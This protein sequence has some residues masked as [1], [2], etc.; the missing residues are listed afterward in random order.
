MKK[1]LFALTLMLVSCAC[2][3]QDYKTNAE[4]GIPL[5]DDWVLVTD[6]EEFTSFVNRRTIQINRDER[7]T[8]VLLNSRD[9]RKAW[10]LTNHKKSQTIDYEKKK[11]KYK[12]DKYHYS[13]LCD[14]RESTAIFAVIYDGNYGNGKAIASEK[15]FP[16]Y[17]G[18]IPDTIGEAYYEY[19]CS[20]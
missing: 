18:V 10:I 12:S 3:S 1:L 15:I 2:L 20:Q 16:Q 11:Q 19:V 13:F 6:S 17:K 8:Q 14:K 7:K 5:S 4:M 9:E